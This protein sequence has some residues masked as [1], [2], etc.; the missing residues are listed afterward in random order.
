MTANQPKLTLNTGEIRLKVENQHGDYLG[1]LVFNPTD[2]VWA[3]KYTQFVYQMQARE[4]DYSQTITEISARVD[5]RNNQRAKLEAG[6]ETYTDQVEELF[7]ENKTDTDEAFRLLN[8]ELDFVKENID[9]LF[10]ETTYKAL[11]G[12]TKS[13][14]GLL[15]FFSQTMQYFDRSRQN[16]TEKYMPPKKRR[17]SKK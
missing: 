8:S 12:E 14:E 15:S 16:V 1:D 11:F 10:G 17:R 7:E 13:L 2:L 5:Q 6:D 3:E 9:A 4:K